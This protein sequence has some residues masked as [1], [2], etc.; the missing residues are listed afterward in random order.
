[1]ARVSK[2]PSLVVSD[3][4]RVPVPGLVQK[5]RAHARYFITPLGH[6]YREP[7]TRYPDGRLLTPNPAGKINFNGGRVSRALSTL[8]FRAFGRPELVADWREAERNV[9]H[10]G[11]LY[12]VWVDPRGPQDEL[13]GRR[14]CTVHDVK[15]VPHGELISY[16]RRGTPPATQLPII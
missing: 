7:C 14:R 9:L 3:D 4:T 16:G 1:M 6:I 12:D 10:D 15:L 11:T 2:R 5:T 8:V 13:T